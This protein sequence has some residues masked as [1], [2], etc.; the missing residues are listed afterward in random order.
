MSDGN[1]NY[2]IAEA[3]QALGV[4]EKTIRR[5]IHR[6][7]IKAEKVPTRFGDT[8]QISELPEE[9]EPLPVGYKRPSLDE[10]KSQQ[11]QLLAQHQ[12]LI[13][14]NETLIGQNRELNNKNLDLARLVGGLQV[15]NQ[16]LS[17]QIKLLEAPQKSWWRKLLRLT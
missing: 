17:G 12:E 14:Q 2:S 3:A 10:L 13:R 9:A 11:D 5:R 1:G 16:Q 4:S 15:Q 6:G 7:E 8:W